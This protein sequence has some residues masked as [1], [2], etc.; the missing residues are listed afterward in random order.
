MVIDFNDIELIKFDGFKGGKGELDSRNY[1]DEDNKIMY[2]VLKP[3]A[4]SGLHT[5]EENSEIAYI[6][7]GTATCYYDGN[8]E[9]VQAGQVHYCPKGHAHY[10]ENRTDEDL[11]YLAIV[12]EHH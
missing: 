2:S 4:R 1:V 3:G 8:E 6:I 11:V 12:G 7:S 5:H 9:V 10:M